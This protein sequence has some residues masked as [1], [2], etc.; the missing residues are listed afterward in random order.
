MDAD[1]RGVWISSSRDSGGFLRCASLWRR[2]A[3]RQGVAGG[4]QP[5]AAGRAAL[6]RF[7]SRAFLEPFGC[8]LVGWKAGTRA[9]ALV[10]GGNSCGRGGRPGASDV[11]VDRHARVGSLTLA[12]RGG[13]IHRALGVVCI[14]RK[15]RPAYRAGHDRH[16]LRGHCAQLARRSQVFQRMARPG[17]IGGLSCVGDRQQSDSKSRTGR[18]NLDRLNKRTGS[19]WRQLDARLYIGCR[20][21]ILAH[22]S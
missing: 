10:G 19:R 17:D 2:Y 18:C 11:W 14:Q 16:C 8:A 4:C 1:A 20:L 12:Q 13:R 22:C 6:S 3:S 5:M 21:A 15:L 7:W 9:M